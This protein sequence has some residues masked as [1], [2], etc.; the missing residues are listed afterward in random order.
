MIAIRGATPAGSRGRA[1]GLNLTLAGADRSK[2]TV[3][4]GN[5]TAGV[6]HTL[7]AGPG[8]V[9]FRVDIET[10]CLAGLAHA[11]HGFEFRTIG[12]DDVD[13]VIVRMNIR[14]HRVCSIGR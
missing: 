9:R 10:Q 11:G 5:L 7:H 2:L 14:F 4:L 3:E 1:P 13:L 8:R 12:H 6:D